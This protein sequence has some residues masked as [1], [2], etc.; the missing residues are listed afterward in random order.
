MPRLP[1]EWDPSWDDDWQAR[2][3]KL[4][5]E[6]EDEHPRKPA[7]AVEFYRFGYASARRQP[8]HD[9]PEVE[10]EM[11]EDYMSGLPEPG[12]PIVEHESDFREGVA[13]AHRGW[14][15]GRAWPSD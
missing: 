15:A 7:E 2:E 5:E 14:E 4:E 3:N 8:T 12:E 9:W 11:Y 13:W 6:I 10:R 1:L